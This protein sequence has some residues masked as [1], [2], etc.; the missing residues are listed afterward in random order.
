MGLGPL[1]LE[2]H[3]DKAT[4]TGVLATIA[5]ALEARGDAARGGRRGDR[6]LPERDQL[7]QHRDLLRAYRALLHKP[8][9]ALGETAG[10]L[11]WREM[12]LRTLVQPLLPRR[13]W[14]RSPD[15]PEAVTALQLR[16]HRVALD[17]LT[18]AQAQV[19][20]AGASSSPWRA[21]RR[22]PTDPIGQRRIIDR[23]QDFQRAVEAVA[24]WRDEVA[25][26]AGDVSDRA[27]VLLALTR[28]FHER[29]PPAGCTPAV[30]RAALMDDAAVSRLAGELERHRA[31]LESLTTRH[32]APLTAIPSAVRTAA[33]AIAAAGLAPSSTVEVEDELT[34][35]SKA[36]SRVSGLR[37]A[38]APV[39]AALGSDVQRV[40]LVQ[41]QTLGEAVRRLAALDPSID[42]I[43]DPRL[44]E[45]DA[46]ALLARAAADAL[47][48]SKT[49]QSLGA[50]RWEAVTERGL[51]ELARSAETLTETPALLQPFSGK[52]K[53]ARRVAEAVFDA[54]PNSSHAKGEALAA[55]VRWGRRAEAFH[56]Q[57]PAR[58]LLGASWRGYESDL[59]GAQHLAAL[60]SELEIDLRR[61]GLQ[62]SDALLRAR[63]S[64]LILWG[65]RLSGPMPDLPE[66]EALGTLETRLQARTPLLRAALDLARATGAE[67]KARLNSALMDDLAG[68][69]ASAAALA[70]EAHARLWFNGAGEE[71][72]A[73]RG[74]VGWVAAL[75]RALTLRTVMSF[76]AE[77]DDPAGDARLLGQLH[78]QGETR[79]SRLVDA[80]NDLARLGD[81]DASSFFSGGPAVAATSLPVLSATAL[82]AEGD[83][84]ALRLHADLGRVLRE[85]RDLGVVATYED[86]LAANVEPTHLADAYELALIRSLLQR[87]LHA[88]GD[89]LSRLS[90]VKLDAI[91]RRFRELDVALA[92]IEAG[93]ILLDWLTAP[94]PA[95]N[96]SGPVATFTQ[97]KLLEH[98]VQRPRARITLRG[99][100]E[101]AG[102][103]MQVVKPVWMMSPTTAAQFAPPHAVRFDLVVIDEA[104]Q[105]TPQM[106]LGALA[107]GAQIIVVGDPKQ[108]P[109]NNAFAIAADT[110][111]D[112]EEE[113]VAETAESVLDLAYQRLG[114]RRRL[115]WHYRSR[116]QQLIEFSN[117]EF[118]GR[119]LVVFPAA[120]APDDFLGVRTIPVADGLYQS[121]LNEPEARVVLNEA[122]G[123]MM[124]R[125]DLSLGIV[126]MN[127][128][129]R[130]LL[131]EMFEDLRSSNPAV[132]DYLAGWEGGVEAFFV[133]N[134]ENVQ[135]DER[136]V[137]IMSTLY[138]PEKVGGPVLQRFGL[139]NRKDEGHRRLNVLVTRAK[140]ANWVVTS[141]RP[142]DVKAGPDSSRG[143]QALQRYLVYAAG[144]PTVDAD[145]PPGTPD[146]DFEIF[147]ADRLRAHGY[148]VT[149]QVGVEGFRIDLGVSHPDASD[150]F[151][152]GVECDGARYH[153]HYTVRD[154]DR[155]RQDV[156]EGLGWRIWRVWSTDWFNDPD[157]ETARLLAWLDSLLEG[158]RARQARR[159]ERAVVAEQ[160][161]PAP[162]EVLPTSESLASETEMHPQSVAA[163]DSAPEAQPP[164]RPATPGRFIEGLELHQPMQ[165][166]FEVWSE[167]GLVGVVE[168]VGGAS[169]PA[170][171]FGSVVRASL[172]QFRATL[173]ATGKIHIASDI[174]EAVRWMRQATPSLL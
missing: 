132:R 87:F 114:A 65:E 128:P 91:R 62:L 31:V 78:V 123:L 15:K 168:R 13:V 156:L 10:D 150:G 69:Q 118:Y 173:E 138:G 53:G 33:E 77:R 57:E 25:A 67:V 144:G 56:S 94:A 101:R 66:S 157:R 160:V 146:S 2:L 35:A 40:T 76:L 14:E 49:R 82:A 74:A 72:S 9:G 162:I 158:A 154:R 149:Y 5:T 112:E 68:A 46:E 58:L 105:M 80:W 131:F 110:L 111:E 161:E 104:S 142:G 28:R 18:N 63:R 126:T 143:V 50:V 52:V 124:S 172:P 85:V 98:V 75:R 71:P 22:L 165:G 99:L 153:S 61:A 41:L 171:L 115:K 90:G 12:R 7:V 93:R 43:R 47:A 48:L 97:R 148:V 119:D 89:D 117:R 3:S 136:D 45:P 32:S 137:I 44:L 39:L 11:I 95:G 29:A 64:D 170:K 20:A 166:Y 130:E 37:T 113:G 140:R 59:E 30:L 125:P 139:F 106:A 1:L 36:L 103:A 92:R 70:E 107:R 34:K 38:L 167:A 26:H 155:I 54:P 16:E 159:S 100:A 81:L 121:G 6:S 60:L 24:T 23:L 84:A 83:E 145:Q 134:L 17:A 152:A 133:K 141:L 122:V 27:D 120:A 42:R 19:H 129:Q 88:S 174:Y 147:V 169:G 79:V 108:L 21:G 164:T 163:A 127:A 116:H 151:L 96:G 135:G 51:A 8:L 102:E 4:K 109:P 55:V 86:T 73:L